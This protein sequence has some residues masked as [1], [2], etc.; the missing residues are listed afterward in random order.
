MSDRI[1]SPRW[2]PVPQPVYKARSPRIY[3]DLSSC[4][5]WFLDHG[6]HWLRS[7][8]RTHPRYDITVLNVQTHSLTTFPHSQS[9]TSWSAA[10]RRCNYKEES[11]LKV[12]G[13]GGS[14][15][16]GRRLEQAICDKGP[17]EEARLHEMHARQKC[18]ACCI[19]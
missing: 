16:H 1:H 14:R 9:T 3:Q 18:R 11:S 13:L 19:L 8:A 4:R 10:R 6:R 2:S 17:N 15:S 5:C 12:R 7:Q